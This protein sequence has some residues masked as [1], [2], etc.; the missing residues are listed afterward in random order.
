MY[1]YNRLVKALS[2][3]FK[4]QFN[5]AIGRQLDHELLLPFLKIG[6]MLI[7]F[8]VSGIKC[9]LSILLIKLVTILCNSYPPYLISSDFNPSLPEA[10]LFASWTII[11]LIS[12]SVK[13]GIS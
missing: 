9:N 13:R 10:L 1:S 3:I 2:Y 6:R 11:Y 7:F 5:K 12:C 4:R 8:I